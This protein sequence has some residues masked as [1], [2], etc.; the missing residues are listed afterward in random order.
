MKAFASLSPRGNQRNQPRRMKAIESTM[1]GV[2][3]NFAKWRGM[4]SM[5]RWE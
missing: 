3:E 4:A 2:P 1:L 5:S